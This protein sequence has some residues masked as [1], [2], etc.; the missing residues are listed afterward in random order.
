[1]NKIANEIRNDPLFT[2]QRFVHKTSVHIAVLVCRGKII[3][4]A[5]N[6]V[7]SRSRG[8]GYS[9]CTIHAEKNVV[10]KLGDY[11]KMQNSDLYIFRKGQNDE[12]LDSKPC[13]DC[14]NFIGKCRDKY[15]LRSV[16]YTTNENTV[17]EL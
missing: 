16:Y 11:R 8:C 6:S 5:C 15:R 1:M 9:N 7:G 17:V 14:F 3:A 10:K 12:F 2:S 4:K 13:M